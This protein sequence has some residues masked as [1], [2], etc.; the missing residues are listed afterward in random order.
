MATRSEK[1]AEEMVRRPSFI[2]AVA[3]VLEENRQLVESAPEASRGLTQEEASLLASA[4]LM[5]DVPA[6]DPNAIERTIAEYASILESALS[7]TAA[8]KQL[9]V[10]PARIRQRLNARTLYGIKRNG[11]WRLPAFQFSKRAE[12]P[13][14]ADIVRRLPDDIHP[15]EFSTWLQ[16]TDPD[17]QI[18][19]KPVSPLRWLRSGGSPKQAAEIAAHL[20]EPV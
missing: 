3:E 11:E 10:E 2:R 19:G 5:V 12:V 8:A 17:L 7:V 1:R 15:V 16:R 4:G 9:K 20:T 18:D 13:G 14:I 6:K